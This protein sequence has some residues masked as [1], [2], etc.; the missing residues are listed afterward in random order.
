MRRPL[1]RFKRRVKDNI[2]MVIK[3]IV[4]SWELDLSGSEQSNGGL[5]WTR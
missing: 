3:E 5:L 1:A 4:W 2:K